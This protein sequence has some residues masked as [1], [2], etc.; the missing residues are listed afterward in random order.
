MDI[1]TDALELKMQRSDETCEETN[2]FSLALMS[3]VFLTFTPNGQGVRPAG[4]Q[5]PNSHAPPWT[6]RAR[7]P[8]LGKA[9]E[10]PVTCPLLLL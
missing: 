4:L 5:G 8:Q 1:K 7:V 9:S 3:T 2:T 10:Q 6:L